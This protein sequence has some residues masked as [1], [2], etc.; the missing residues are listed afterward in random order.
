MATSHSN[1]AV[2]IRSAGASDGPAILHCLAAAFLPYRD[3]YTPAAYTD[4]VLTP[5]TIQMRLKQMRTVVATVAGE[6]VGTIAASRASETGHLRGMA[7]LPQWH[8]KGIAAKLL[9]SIEDWLRCCGCAKVTLNTTP[10]LSAAMR[11]YEKHGYRRSG[12]VSDFFGMA[13]IE[14]EKK[15]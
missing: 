2:E 8:G 4:T 3:Q 15:L 5:E 10:P 6:V 7:V 14:Y 13:L 11:F 9:A 12:R 1:A